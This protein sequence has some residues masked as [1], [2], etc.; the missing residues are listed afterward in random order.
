MIGVDRA[1]RQLIVAAGL[2]VAT[3][4]IQTVAVV[5]L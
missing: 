2:M 1:P 3:A 5:M 4:L